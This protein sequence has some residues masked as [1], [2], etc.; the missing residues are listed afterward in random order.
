[1]LGE[2]GVLSLQHIIVPLCASQ[3][4]IRSLQAASHLTGRERG[5]WDGSWGDPE[6]VYANY[7]K[8]ILRYGPMLHDA[9]QRVA[10]GEISDDIP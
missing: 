8:M 7:A 2:A 5:C 6:R 4:N 3:A 9:R 10:T 1:M